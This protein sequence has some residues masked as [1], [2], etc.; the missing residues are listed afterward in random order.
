VEEEEAGWPG[1]REA[2]GAELGQWR[3]E[4]GEEV[5]ALSKGERK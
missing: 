5:V 2:A 3:D 1:P 4:K